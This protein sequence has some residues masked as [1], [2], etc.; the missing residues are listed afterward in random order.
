MTFDKM[1]S[2]T[3]YIQA[4]HFT[5]RKGLEMEDMAS[6]TLK[7]MFTEKVLISE[8]FNLKL[9]PKYFLAEN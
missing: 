2:E 4:K 9:K 3:H 8:E 7:L 5:N 1:N 6:I